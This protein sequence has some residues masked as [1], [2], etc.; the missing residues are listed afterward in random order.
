KESSTW[1]IPAQEVRV[2]LDLERLAALGISPLQ[3]V[4]AIQRTNVTIPGGVVDAGA[5]RLSVKTSG[6][7]ASLEQIRDTVVSGSADGIVHLAD[8]A[9]IALGDGDPKPIA[10]Y[11]GRRAIFV[12]A[13]MKDGQAVFAVRR[14]L[15]AQVDAIRAELPPVIG[16][17]W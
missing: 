10:R 1:G 5:P 13:A 8:V 7:Y 6:D 3:V 2:A 14:E 9:K 15:G 17:H 12:R 16:A 11:N 4:N